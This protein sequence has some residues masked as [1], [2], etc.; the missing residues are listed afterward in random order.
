[1]TH[2]K[3]TSHL[4]RA[5]ALLLAL[6][7]AATSLPAQIRLNEAA[8]ANRDL[9]DEDGDT[10][11][12]L[13]L[14]NLGDDT[15]SL[16]DWS[17]SDRRD[18]PR[19]WVFGP[20]EIVP[21]AHDLVWASGKDRQYAPAREL[22]LGPGDPARYRVPR[23]PVGAQ[24]VE[25]GFADGGWVTG[26]TGIGFGDGDDATVVPDGTRA[27]FLRQSFRLDDLAAL[28]QLRLY[29]DF[30]DGFV[31]YV[32][33]VE[34]A[35]AN[36]AGVRPPY[37]A[38]AEADH[39]AVLPEGLAPRSYVIDAAASFLREGDNVLAVQVHNHTDRSTDLSLV[40]FLLAGY[41]TPRPGTRPA[42]P[43]LQIPARYPHADFK[44]SSAGETVY[45]FDADAR[46]VDSLAVRDVPAFGSVG[47]SPA[48]GARLLY[49]VPTPGAPND[50]TGYTSQ[51]TGEVA[52]S[53][54]PGMYTRAFALT[55]DGATPGTHVRYTLDA[56]A[57]TAESPRYTQRLAIRETTV[58]RA[59]LFP[60][61]TGAGVRPGPIQT[62]TFFVD[63][64]PELD[65]VALSTDPA[66][67]FDPVDGIYVLGEEYSPVRPFYGANFWDDREV[68]MHFAYFPRDGAA[69]FSLDGGARIFGGYTRSQAQ[70]SFAFF[71][72]GAYGA[73]AIEYPLFP[74]RDY[75]SFPSVVLRNAGNDWQYAYMRDATL[76][77]LMSGSGLDYADHRPVAAYLNGEYWGL[78][79]LRE[80][81][82][83]D[84]LAARH[85]GVD[86]DEIDLL[87]LNGRVVEGDNAD[88]HALIAYVTETDLTDDAAFARVAAEI[89]LDNF[90][91]YQA[92]QIYIDNRD[93]PGNN[94]KFWRAPGGKWRWIM[95]DTDFGASIFNGGAY[96]TNTLDHATTA[97]GPEWPNP[98]W[99]TL[100]LR[101][102]LTNE[103]F[104][105]RFI[106]RMADEMNRRFLPD[107]AIALIDENAARIAPEIGPTQQRWG[108]ARNWAEQVQR[109]RTFFR[110]RPGFVRRH[111]LE[112]FDLPR[113]NRLTVA[114]A[115]TVAGVVQV[116]SLRVAEDSWSGFYYA[117]VPVRVAAVAKTGHTF[118]HWRHDATLTDPVLTVDLQVART[119]EPVW[120]EGATAV[121]ES[122]PTTG[123]L[124]EVEAGPNPT[125][126]PLVVGFALSAPTDITVCV[127]DVLGRVALARDV[128]GLGAGAQSVT[129]DL[130]GLAAGSYR[131]EVG[132]RAGGRTVVGVVLK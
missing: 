30:D 47:R 113:V 97:S 51:I 37:D 45:L 63:V 91:T 75:S 12:W 71:A 39:E 26:T 42:P 86:A 82:N 83:E 57:P 73:S 114:N 61:S 32:N 131:V 102:L 125:A 84:F 17:L 115:D 48:D 8:P 122:G 79:N 5:A 101:R 90:A 77:Q 93:W 49:E 96:R 68:P 27:V 124:S 130:S 58:V 24:W 99:S 116:N 66:L 123:L 103:S 74:R 43:V 80:K 62:G 10:P 94:I 76:T 108:R 129:L 121:R 87:E 35:R 70:R 118:S 72:R 28:R 11:D 110:E 2:S 92:A 56:S 23:S 22:L 21:G 52:F 109:M 18:E 69:G 40:P 3:S 55:M 9:R 7:T 20:T 100:L 105:H 41:E 128:G 111:F 33:G 25:L 34:V 13:E 38:L 119:F 16:T 112:A 29:V 95:F 46:P 15:V 117:S 54:A 19:K 98:P 1:M 6:T 59:R 44:I 50:S 127:V 81:I 67:L 85:P 53:R 126:G 14:A 60:D 107:H 106:N 65:V 89:D 78:Y 132:D 31:A 120:R 104:R 36:M 4:P 88:Y 64:E